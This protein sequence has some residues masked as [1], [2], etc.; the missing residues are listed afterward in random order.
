MYNIKY[1]HAYAFHSIHTHTFLAKCFYAFF[2]IPPFIYLPYVCV[3]VCVFCLWS[4]KHGVYMWV[5]FC[6]NVCTWNCIYIYMNNIII[7]RRHHHD[8]RRKQK[9]KMYRKKF[10]M[11]IYYLILWVPVRKHYI[12]TH[13]VFKFLL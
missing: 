13:I 9:K 12:Q 2:V 5:F 3:Y 6:I 10:V 4:N 1:I 11:L 7:V 8:L